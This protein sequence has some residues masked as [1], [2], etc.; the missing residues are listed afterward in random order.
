MLSGLLQI[1]SCCALTGEGLREAQLPS[2]K[3]SQLCIHY[4]FQMQSGLNE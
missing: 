2:R 4:V 3:C 1:Q